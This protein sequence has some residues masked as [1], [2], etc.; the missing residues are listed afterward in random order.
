MKPTRQR[1]LDYLH[2]HPSSS[3]FEMSQALGL[4]PVNIRYHLQK[5]TAAGEL[6]PAESRVPHQRGRPTCLYR[7]NREHQ[8][9]NL[10]AL[11]HGLLLELAARLSP[12][13]QQA[14]WD[15]LAA[16]LAG[17]QPLTSGTLAR[18]LAAAVR[19]LNH[20]SYQARWEARAGAPRLL[21]GRCPYASLLG[22][23]PEVCRIDALYLS[24]LLGVSVQHLMQINLETGSPAA[25][26]FSVPPPS[27]NPAA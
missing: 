11:A 12:E 2:T 9:N 8:N 17:Q 3:A 23:H 25:C 27:S 19:T 4:T 14:A 24:R 16:S 26:V 21:L 13:D 6:E 10:H 22:E 1:I 5:M 7:I 18:R 15:H 20:Q